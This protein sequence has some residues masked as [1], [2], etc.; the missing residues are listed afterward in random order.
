MTHKQKSFY[1][2]LILT[3]LGIFFWFGG[4]ISAIVFGFVFKNEIAV[5]ICIGA[6]LIGLIV[7]ILDDN[8]TVILQLHFQTFP[9]VTFPANVEQKHWLGHTL[10][11]VES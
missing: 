10:Y 6:S 8:L 7:F 4:F 1:K 5:V 9:T 11:F 3:I 2:S